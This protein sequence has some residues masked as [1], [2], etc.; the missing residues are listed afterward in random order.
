MAHKV[1]PLDRSGYWQ[2]IGKS[3][4]GAQELYLKCEKDLSLELA[5]SGIKLRVFTDLPDINLIC[6]IVNKDGNSSLSRMNELNK[7]I[8]DELKFDP[9][10]IT[11][12]PEFMIS[13]TEFT[14]DQYGLEGFDGKNSM[15]EHLQVLGISS[16]EF[17]SVGRVS[18]LRCTI[19]NPWCA[20][21]RG[22]KPDYVEV[23]A[24]TL[25][26][27]IERVVSNLSL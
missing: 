6:F 17:G 5:S 20:L 12:R 8:C 14:Y 13:I 7:A 21:S 9:A 1:V 11:K 19:I 24:T 22:G 26:A 25:K 16:R 15:D 10:E 23:F 2:L 27:T 18:V 4:Q 3:I